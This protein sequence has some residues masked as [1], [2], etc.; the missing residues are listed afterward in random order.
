[1]TPTLKWTDVEDIAL[2]LHAQEPDTDPLTVRF[3]ALRDK[4]LA[5][6]GF[7]DDPAHV[8]EKIL[9]AVQMAWYEEYQQ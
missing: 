2:L 7:A 1:M 6:P 3:T 5:L 8:N 9:E 4:V